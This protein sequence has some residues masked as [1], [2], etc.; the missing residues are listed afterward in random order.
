[1]RMDYAY[2]DF[3]K[4]NANN[5]DSIRLAT[6]TIDEYKRFVSELEVIRKKEL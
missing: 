2:F 4:L 1:M 6:F 5:R 3:P